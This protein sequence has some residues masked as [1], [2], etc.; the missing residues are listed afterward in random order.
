MVFM[1]LHK[2]ADGF[3]SNA[4]FERFYWPTL[5][6]IAVGLIDAGLVPQLFAEGG[7]E[8]RLEIISDLPKGT[9]LWWFDRTDMARAWRTKA[10]PLRLGL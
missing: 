2:G 5:R 6:K 10:A 7:S 3:M 1:P 9:T 4:Q 8:Q